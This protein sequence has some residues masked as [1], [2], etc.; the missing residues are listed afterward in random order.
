MRA[1]NIEVSEGLFGRWVEWFTPAVQPFLADIELASSVGEQTAEV[2]LEAEVRDTYCLYGLP[3]GRRHAFDRIEPARTALVVI[4]MVPFFVTQMEYCHGIVPNISR[5]ASS[6]RVAGGTVAWVL[7]GPSGRTAL[8]VEFFGPE[9]AEA[10]QRSGG[11]G[12]LRERLWH[13]F[14]VGHADLLVEK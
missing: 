4:D 11:Q 5:L 1:L 8:D 12:P 3:D 13:E 14:E 6:L 9:V 2:L 7:P 10:Y